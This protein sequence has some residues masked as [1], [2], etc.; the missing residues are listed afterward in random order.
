V[1]EI[2]QVPNWAGKRYHSLNHHLRQ[3]FGQK[4]FKISLDAGFSCPNRDGSKSIGGCAFCSLRG[5]GDFAG[6]RQQNIEEQFE[7]VR[8]IMH[9]KW[10]QGKYIA[11]YQAFTNTYAPPEQLES[12]YT[13]A[14]QQPGVVGLA[15]ATRPDCLPLPVI[16]LLD[17]INRKTYLWVELGLQTIHSSTAR[18]MNMHYCFTDFQRA[19]TELRAR[20]IETCTHV[21]LGL[22]GENVQDM[23]ETGRIVAG[24]DIQGI[25][26]HLLHLMQG[27]GL[28]Y[29]YQD[30]PFSFL[31]PLEYVD[32]VIDLL[33]ILPPR[34]VIHRLT[35]DSPRNLLIG[36][37]WSLNKWEVLNLIDRRL[38]ERNT[39][40]GKYASSLGRS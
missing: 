21:I 29:L 32:L 15:I 20:N 1:K 7:Q 17:E 13:L 4:V 33:E 26:I 22:P 19:L 14:L 39:W 23:R 2:V 27:T 8:S 25:K 30:N 31:E 12:L 3:K 6:D 35:G 38:E 10:A 18:D 37:K 9:R 28:A 16:E 24:L 40:Q 11:Y 36:P 34:V 5:S